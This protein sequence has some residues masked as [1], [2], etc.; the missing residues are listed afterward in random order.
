MQFLR[1]KSI[2]LTQMLVLNVVLALMF[3]LQVQFLCNLQYKI[4][5]LK[6]AALRSGLSFLPKKMAGMTFKCDAHNF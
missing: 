3:V 6:K 1:A 4:T 5:D 2:Q